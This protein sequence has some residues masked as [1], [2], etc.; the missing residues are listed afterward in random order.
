MRDTLYNS[1]RAVQSLAASARTDGTA[2]GS[3]V[4]LNLNEQNFRTAMAVAHAATVTDG[5]IAVSVEES[6][7]GTTG[8]AAVPEARR[9]GGFPTLDSGDSNTVAEVG[10][11]VDPRKPFLRAVAT[12]SGATAGGT[13]GALFLLGTPGQEPVIR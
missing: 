5:S 3:A 2:N 8:W 9:L 1:L 12:T 11:V 6:A 4:D 7:D 10:I 13:V